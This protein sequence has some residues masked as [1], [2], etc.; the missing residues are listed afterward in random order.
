[1]LGTVEQQHRA[2]P[3]NRAEGRIGLARPQ[4]VRGPSEHLL[5]ARG[6]EDH[7]ESRVEQRA[8]GDDLAV[9]PPAGIEEAPRHEN[10]AKRLDE[11][12]DRVAYLCPNAPSCWS[13]TS[14]VPLAGAVLVAINTRLAPRRG[15]AT[16]A[17]HSGPELLVV[18]AS[19]GRQRP[20]TD[21]GDGPRDRRTSTISGRQRGDYERPARARPDD[22]LPWEVDDE[23]ATIAIN[24]TSGTTGRPKGVMYTHRGAYLNALG[25]VV[26]QRLRP[27]APSTCGRCRCSTATAGAPPG[28]SP[29]SPARHVCLREVARRRDV[30]A[31]STREGVTHLTARRPC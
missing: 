29:P 13:R 23:R 27:R 11:P 7:H 31:A 18:D 2:L 14:R 6:L 30:A 20:V 26:H 9:A 19:C 21:A 22:P 15:R 3:Y 8:E 1:M 16:S 17:T 28:R 5:H 25:E 24:Y 10:E 12:G 4:L